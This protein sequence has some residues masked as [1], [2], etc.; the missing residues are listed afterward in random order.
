[1]ILVTQAKPPALKT[2][3]TLNFFLSGIFKS[4]A[5][6]RGRAKMIKSE[7][8]EM[9]ESARMSARWLKHLPGTSWSQNN[10]TGRHIIDL[11][12]TTGR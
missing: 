9:T 12:M 5:K 1:M 3:A 6:G 10:L 2:A 11:I 8:T 7:R 4:L